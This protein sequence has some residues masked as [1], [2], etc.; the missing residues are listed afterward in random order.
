STALAG[1]PM[2]LRDAPAL[3]AAIARKRDFWLV[4]TSAVVVNGISYF[5]A[6]WIPLYLKT[7][8]GFGF[9]S[10]NLLSIFVYG[11]LDAGNLLTG[12]FVRTAVAR[13]LSLGTARN[14]ALAA[15]C[16]LMTGAMGVGVV[17]SPYIALALLV[18]TAIGV[19][20]FL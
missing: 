18:L 10:G 9:G 5:L 17:A 7:E 12:I 20:G 6:D 3:L 14:R 2:R 15:S 13:G 8:R 1:K 4:A 16:I 11:G 19:A